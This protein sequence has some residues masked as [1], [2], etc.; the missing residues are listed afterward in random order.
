MIECPECNG[1]GAVSRVVGEEVCAD[2]CPSC[3][4]TG[5]VTEVMGDETVSPKEIDG[6]QE[7]A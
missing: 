3:G 7:A 1:T 4:G 2:R 6:F 5:L